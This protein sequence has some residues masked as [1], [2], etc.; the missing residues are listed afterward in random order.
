MASDG[1]ERELPVDCPHCPA[2]IETKDDAMVHA[3]LH[4]GR[5]ETEG[6]RDAE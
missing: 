6:D 3:I 2:T 1:A 4:S 5:S